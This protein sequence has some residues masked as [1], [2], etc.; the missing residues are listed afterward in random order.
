MNKNNKNSNLGLIFI[1][2]FFVIVTCIVLFTADV[3]DLDG[4]L[5]SIRTIIGFVIF[6]IIFVIV[7][8]SI[9]NKTQI[10]NT[11]DN[12]NKDVDNTKYNHDRTFHRS[13]FERIGI[14]MKEFAIY[15]NQYKKDAPSTKSKNTKTATK[16]VEEEPEIAQEAHEDILKKVIS[17]LGESEF[18]NWRETY[19]ARQ[20]ST[21]DVKGDK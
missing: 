16:V 7:F 19:E 9:K 2:P 3:I 8:V 1:L 10:N 12:V 14:D 15:K 13:E 11:N 17:E 21:F 4:F 20:N 6:A 5:F 18:S